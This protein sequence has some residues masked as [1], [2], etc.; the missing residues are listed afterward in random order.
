MSSGSPKRS[1]SERVSRTV[2]PRD[3]LARWLA[4]ARNRHIMVRLGLCFL[5]AM[6]MWLLTGAWAPSFP[7][8]TGY[9]PPRDLVARTPFSVLDEKETEARRRQ[10]RSEVLNIYDHD[11]RP[12]V[13]LRRALQNQVITLVRSESEDT[14][15]EV[16]REFLPLRSDVQAPAHQQELQQIRGA[17]AEDTDL[18]RFERAVL[19]ALSDYERDGLLENLVHGLEEGSQTAIWVQP[20]GAVTGPPAEASTLHRVEVRDVRIAE[21]TADLEQRLRQGFESATFSREQAEVLTRRAANWLRNKKLPSTLSIN[22]ER[23]E[24]ARREAEAAVEPVMFTYKEGDRLVV[25]RQALRPTDIL[26]LRREYEAI[27]E[28]VTAGDMLVRTLAYL[29]MY[30]AM[31]VLCGTY[32]YFHERRLLTDLRRLLTVLVLVVVTVAMCVAA[33]RDAWRAEIIPLS[34]FAMTLAIAYHRELALITSAAVALSVVL[35]MG[36]DL[37]EF[38]ILM[39]AAS[40]PVLLIRRIRHRTKLIYIGMLAGAVSLLTT[41]GVGALVGQSFGSPQSSLPFIATL[42]GDSRTAF[43]LL[44]M[45]GAAWYGFCSVLAGLLMTGLLPFIERLFDV[46]TDLSLLELGDASHPLLQELARRAPGTYNH[47]INVAS[48]GEAAADAVGAN[49]LLVRVGAYFHDIGKMAKPQY[50]VENQGQSPS[51]HESLLPAMS[52]LVIIAHVKDG[53]ELARR[54][55]LPQSIVDFIEQHH[56]T[57]L[58]EYFYDQANKLYANDPDRGEVDET[59]FRYPGPKPQSKEA[60]VMMLAD[61][62]ES[63]SRAL[64]EPTPARIEGLIHDIAM[65]RLLDGQFDQCALTLCE[66]ALIEDSLVKSLTAVYHS[67]LKYPDQQT[68]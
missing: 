15:S 26:L 20:A 39:A 9:I 30:V 1:R 32:V 25:G 13:E 50:F 63:A 59:S 58:V 19:L 7:Y 45:S 3:G 62:V 38:I 53:A 21:A 28:R 14:A 24:Q 49:G 34:L 44:L 40:A 6:A 66:L 8:R 65:K 68:A 61:A 12:L 56:G 57:T 46:Q 47:S 11:E 27:L 10:S 16:W 55:H 36:H 54:H 52:T 33:S 51:R 48:L 23:S 41:A 2:A 18:E 31:Y 42:A 4:I 67:R 35:T 37:A 22:R 60:A 5:A 64:V 43:A 17:L 29:G